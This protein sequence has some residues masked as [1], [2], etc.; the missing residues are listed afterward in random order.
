[1]IRAPE[2]RPALPPSV[3]SVPDLDAPLPRPASAAPQLL[4]P[5][6]KTATRNSRWAVVPALWPT[7]SS[8]SNQLSERP[9]VETKAH[10]A[11]GLAG[12][13]YISSQLG[14]SDY[15]DRGWKTAGF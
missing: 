14:T 12:S 7:K 5:R 10:E 4:D 11:R 15:D 8:R 3:Q 9:T 1:V 13:P 6:D 2:L